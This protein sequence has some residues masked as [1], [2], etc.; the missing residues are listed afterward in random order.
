MLFVC[1]NNDGD[2]VGVWE[3]VIV[4]VCGVVCVGE[5]GY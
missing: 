1:V 2:D 4:C 3:V 5:V